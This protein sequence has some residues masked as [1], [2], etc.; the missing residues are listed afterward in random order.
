MARRSSTRV[1][2]YLHTRQLLLGAGGAGGA[3]PG[4]RSAPDTQSPLGLGAQSLR[5]LQSL[6]GVLVFHATHAGFALHAAQHAAGSTTP[7][8]SCTVLARS[9]H[10]P[11]WKHAAVQLPV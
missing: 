9:W 7:G 5:S 11:G 10:S 2:T 4:T 1:Y 6:W 8:T 3:G